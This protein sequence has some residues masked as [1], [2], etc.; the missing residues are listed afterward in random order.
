MARNEGDGSVRLHVRLKHLL[1]WAGVLLVTGAA[2]AQAPAPAPAPAPAQAQAVTPSAPAQ[3]PAA[4]PPAATSPSLWSPST[5]L[6]WSGWFGRSEKPRT[7]L[8]ITDPYAEV[9]TGPGRGFP[10][11][12]VAGR[13]ETI[14]VLLRYTDWYK[15]RTERG[16]EGWVHREQL[17]STLTAT[18]RPFR[19]VLVE[20]VLRRRGE[21][22]AAWGKFKS[23]PMLKVWGAYRLT[24][25]GLSVEATV[26]Q[27]QGVFSGSDFWQI[28]LRMEPWAEQRWSPS[29]GI[30]IGR[31]R[32]IPN[33]SLVGAIN[34]EANMSNVTLGLRYR[35]TERFLVRTDF[36]LY[37][38]NVADTRNDEFRAINL[39][40]AFSF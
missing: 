17:M 23:E 5:W 15:V 10:V 13:H 9:R 11:T 12:Q 21:V 18:Q 27:V 36:A 37:T 31:F 1:R 14:E 35:V 8:T 38:A 4:T 19:D 25:A 39:G 40:V 29:L 33:T 6:D 24:D 3:A 26:G 16:Y 30:G 28:G 7:L 32:N 20:D 22:G 34:T 2:H